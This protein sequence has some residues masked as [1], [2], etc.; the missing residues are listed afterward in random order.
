[1]IMR[2]APIGAFGAMA[3]TIGRYGIGTLWVLGKLMT[4]V[5]AACALFVF[6][7]LG[8]I[9]LGRGSRYGSRGCVI[10]PRVRGNSAR[11]GPCVCPS[12]G[13]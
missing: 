7:V 3:F 1:M 2:L 10:E 11:F 12:G 4:G 9:T 5:Y 8:S 6:I 13:A